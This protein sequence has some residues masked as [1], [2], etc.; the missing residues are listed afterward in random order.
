MSRSTA[1][2]FPAT[3]H[4]ATDRIVGTVTRCIALFTPRCCKRIWIPKK[5]I[6]TIFLFLKK[7]VAQ[8]ELLAI[9]EL[10]TRVG[11]QFLL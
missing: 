2:V 3:A 1:T 8:L 4:W 7:K 10:K 11:T 5:Y 6:E 9:E